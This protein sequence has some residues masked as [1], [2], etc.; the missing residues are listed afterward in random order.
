MVVWRE[1]LG[2]AVILSHAT[3][4]G[5]WWLLLT[6][7]WTFALFGFDKWRAGRAHASRLRESTLL[8]A[9]ALGGWPGGLAGMLLFRH[10]SAKPSFQGKFAGILMLWVALGAAGYAWLG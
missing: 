4:L 5:F 10:K 7:A 6:S 9:A 2:R 8:W 3:R 1:S